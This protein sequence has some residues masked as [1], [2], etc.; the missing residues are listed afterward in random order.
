MYI[1]KKSSVRRVVDVVTLEVK[2]S[3]PRKVMLL[4]YAN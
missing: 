1:T 3:C 4:E 2:E